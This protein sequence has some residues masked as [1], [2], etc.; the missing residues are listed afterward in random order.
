MPPCCISW[1]KIIHVRYSYSF[2][3]MKRLIF[4]VGKAEY[5]AGMDAVASA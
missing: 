3:R 2:Y 4:V 5:K 1:Q